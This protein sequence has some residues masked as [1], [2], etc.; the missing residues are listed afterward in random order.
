MMSMQT[1][2]MFQ[3][4]LLFCVYF[5]VII[6][7]P[8]LA[9]H[10]KL[11]DRRIADQIMFYFLVGNFYLMSLVFFLELL[12]ISNRVTLILGTIVPF[13]VL[14]VV[15]NRWKVGQ[16]LL[17]LFRDS[18]MLLGK[19]LGKKTFF[20]RGFDKVKKRYTRQK[21]KVKRLPILLRLDVVVFLVS[22]IAMFYF[23]GISIISV[24]GYSVSDMAVHN[25]WINAL[26]ENKLFVAGIYPEGAHCIIYYLHAVFGFDTYIILGLLGFIQVCSIV[27]GALLFMKLCCKNRYL[28][29]IGF[30]IFI[31]ANIWN[32]ISY[33]RYYSA[34][35]QEYGMIFI[36][37]AVYYGF[38][39]FDRQ[40]QYLKAKKEGT[41]P[42]EEVVS[43]K[44]LVIRK[45]KA[46]L[47][48]DYSISLI[49]FALSFALTFMVHF[50]NTMIL[51]LA[52]VAMA[53]G[54]IG[55]FVRKDYILKILATCFISLF[56]AVLPMAIS[57]AFGTPLQGSLKWGMNVITGS[58]NK[59][60]T[61][62][63]VNNQ[64]E[65]VTQT[66]HSV[67][68]SD[69]GTTEAVVSETV[70]EDFSSKSISTS[71]VKQNK[72]KQIRNQAKAKYDAVENEVTQFVFDGKHRE[73]FSYILLAVLILFVV[74]T[75]S[76][77][78]KERCY[79]CMLYTI[80]ITMIF[81]IVLLCAR[82]FHLPSLMDTNRARIYCAFMMPVT[83]VVAVDSI[84]ALPT[85]KFS[86]T[87]TVGMNFVG[88]SV[89]V[90]TI[91]M[92]VTNGY[93]R[94]PVDLEFLQTNQA[95]T[96][97]TNI[98]R[99]EKDYS[100]TILSAN[101]ELQM[102]YDHGYHYEV[103]TFLHDME[104]LNPEKPLYI[105]T[106]K[107]FVFVEK[108]PLNYAGG[109]YLGG[110]KISEEYAQERLPSKSL[111]IDVYKHRN[112][113]ICMSRMYYWMQS[114]MKMYPND[115]K[116]YYEDDVFVCY[117]ITQNTYSLFNLAIDYGYNNVERAGVVQ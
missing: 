102:G 105:P 100:W 20:Y 116:A 53:I 9:L 43:G 68:S 77:V 39:Y 75:I 63:V 117:E 54:Y 46:F 8:Y 59:T 89:L 66:D 30:F 71:P 60:E 45:I 1:Y 10:R 27:Y 47:K 101:D 52:C 26:G 103:I 13:F 69:E 3:L 38:D 5:G 81:L 31:A 84:F 78:V 24:F 37:P 115:V 90:Y 29:Y 4:I 22:F 107:I 76:H 80:G 62:T 2:Y 82:Q 55:L 112:R 49:G 64:N 16:F 79:G 93:I 104:K 87:Y 25:Y 28:P 65:A 48:K 114:F 92:M 51:G 41:I 73:Y 6:G 18:Q 83:L 17:D 113:M 67:V 72:W 33:F 50:Y 74:G 42:S 19:R 11:D 86:S 110:E 12:H 99:N 111:S 97:L 58:S 40:Y 7:L 36:L 56:L 34:L 108:K 44:N 98:I 23:Y 88:F 106:E 32:Y 91:F 96:T 85:F 61:S 70:S 35:P 94:T 21:Q 15:V 109:F 95:V 57:F 14:A